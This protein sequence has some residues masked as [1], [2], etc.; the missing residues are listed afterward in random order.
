VSRGTQIRLFGAATLV[1]A[2]A[3]AGI[4]ATK[5]SAPPDRE[6]LK[7][8]EFLRQMEM[9][10]QM[11]MLRDMQHLE[12]GAAPTAPTQKAPTKKPETSK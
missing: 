2:L 6:M 12:D 8:I 1:L 3:A 5:E 7:M 4:A 9:I 10:K 11:D